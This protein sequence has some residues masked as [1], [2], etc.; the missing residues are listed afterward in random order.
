MKTEKLKDL[1]VY[2]S[3]GYQKTIVKKEGKQKSEKRYIRI[4]FYQPEILE[5]DTWYAIN[6][7]SLSG[8]LIQTLVLLDGPHR[9]LEKFR[10]HNKDII[11]PLNK[12]NNGFMPV[13]FDNLF[14]YY[15]SKKLEINNYVLLSGN[16][17][18][19]EVDKNKIDPYY[20]ASF[21]SSKDIQNYFCEKAKGKE[22]TVITKNKIL[23]IEIPRFT[24]LEEKRIA[25][26]FKMR[27][28]DLAAKIK[29]E[30]DDVF[31]TPLKDFIKESDEALKNKDLDKLKELMSRVDFVVSD[32]RLEKWRREQEE[33]KNSDFEELAG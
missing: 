10:L 19:L 21:L 9:E 31:V 2:I 20:V 1:C 26:N 25:N 18:V 8:N 32:D 22:K 13:V 24:E 3:R 17:A 5:D 7:S 29:E 4:P 27:Q 15:D 33:K 16:L 23:D 28:I 11:I 6:M 12:N 30:Q 14:P